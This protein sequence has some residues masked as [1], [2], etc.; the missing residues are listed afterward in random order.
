MRK[1]R[2]EDG[3]TLIELMVVVLIIGILVG[4]ALPVFL[5]A[6][7][8]ATD[9]AA[10]A[11]LGNGLIAAKTWFTEFEAY[12]GFDE[13]EGASVEPS[14][15]WVAFADPAVGEVAVGGVSASDL[16]LVAESSTGTFFCV[17]DDVLA[18]TT[19]GTGGSFASVDTEAE[20][21]SPAW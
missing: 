19:Y 5:G 21:A 3:F 20:C 9:R 4:V 6:R 2:A 13:T 11:N 8:E 16:H 18:G 1:E 15:R 17:H 7:A 14:L 12:S 10:Q